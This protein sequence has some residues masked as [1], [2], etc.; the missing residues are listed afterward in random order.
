MG[1]RFSIL[2]WTV[3]ENGLWQRP[4]DSSLSYTK[5]KSHILFST[6]FLC[7]RA[8]Q[9]FA[10]NPILRCAAWFWFLHPCSKVCNL[11]HIL[12]ASLTNSVALTVNSPAPSVTK[13]SGIPTSSVKSTSNYPDSEH[14]VIGTNLVK[15]PCVNI[16]A[17]LLPLIDLTL[18]IRV[19]TNHVPRNS[20]LCRWR[21]SNLSRIVMGCT[22]VQ[23]LCCVVTSKVSLAVCMPTFY[24]LA[25]S[26]GPI[27]EC[28][29]FESILLTLLF[30]VQPLTSLQ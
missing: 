10:R 4:Q 28:R 5:P 8:L 11:M 25:N 16:L 24:F 29:A 1:F 27:R 22:A 14:A 19:S 23:T 13:F 21:W 3:A 30:S 2:K 20:G 15:L 17:H 18:D 12:R 9:S 7:M 6:F 26:S